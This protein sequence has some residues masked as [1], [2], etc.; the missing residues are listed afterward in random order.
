MTARK[1]TRPVVE[2]KPY[3]G[4]FAATFGYERVY[5]LVAPYT[6]RADAKRGMV[7]FLQRIG[8]DSKKIKWSK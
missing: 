6:R 4:S 8:A 3:F 5:V 1:D 7:R 2:I